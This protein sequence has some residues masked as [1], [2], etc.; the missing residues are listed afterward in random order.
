MIIGVITLPAAPGFLAIPSNA[1][2]IALPCP[3]EP[4]AAATEMEKA[5]PRA[6]AIPSMVSTF[7]VPSAAPSASLAK[8]TAQ[9]QNTKSRSNNADIILFLFIINNLSFQN[10]M[11]N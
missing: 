3:M 10:N 1:A 7:A 2:A 4:N 9:T 11:L 5:A 8:A 6:I